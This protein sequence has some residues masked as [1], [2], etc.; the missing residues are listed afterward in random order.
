MKNRKTLSCA[1]IK[2]TVNKIPKPPKKNKE[3]RNLEAEFGVERYKNSL[4]AEEIQENK[5][6]LIHTSILVSRLNSLNS[7]YALLESS[8][9]RS[10]AIQAKQQEE[11]EN[12]KYT[13]KLL[14]TSK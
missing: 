3:F 10:K 13:L 5:Q 14:K 12:L 9:Q 4:L 1:T 6:K 2:K 7:D 8:V 11:I